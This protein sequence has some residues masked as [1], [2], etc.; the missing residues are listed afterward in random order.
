MYVPG[1]TS[2]L[3][4]TGPPDDPDLSCI[5]VRGATALGGRFVP[6]DKVVELLS[7]D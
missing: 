3:F 7:P 6:M 2:M 1:K 5:L 4:G